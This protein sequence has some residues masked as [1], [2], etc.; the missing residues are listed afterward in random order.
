MTSKP[1]HNQS[2]TPEDLGRRKLFKL[3]AVAAGLAATG[4]AAAWV[5]GRIQGVP[6]DGGFPMPVDE[7][8]LKP[9]SQRNWIFSQ[10]GSEKNWAQFPE[11]D[12]A[13]AELIGEPGWSFR[14]GMFAASDYTR[15]PEQWDDSKPGYQQIDW[16][17]FCAASHPL[18]YL[19]KMAKFGQPDAPGI[20]GWQQKNLAPVQWKFSSRQDAATRIKRAASLFGA[21]RVGITYNDPRWNYEPMYNIMESK[22]VSWE[23]Y[24]FKPKTVIVMLHE[25]DYDGIRTSPAATSVGAVNKAYTDMALVAGSLADFIRRLGYQAVASHNDSINKVAYGIMAGLGEGA[26]NG[27]LVAPGLGPRVRISAV[28]TDLDFVEYDK[29]RNFG[30]ME[31]CRHCKLCADR[32]PSKAITFDDEPS[33]Q[34]TFEG[35]DNPDLAWHGQKGVL[36]YY[37]DA[38]KCYKFWADNNVACTN[39]IKS[40]PWNKPDFWHHRLIDASNT[41]TRGPIHS[42][43]R[44]MDSLFGYGNMDVAK[45]HKLFWHKEV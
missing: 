16:A 3:S 22:E 20:C 18:E 14:D 11:R 45:A 38:K 4:G 12:T 30:I 6:F 8:L 37:N 28:L 41:F 25:M 42:F 43:M 5:G 32:C 2:D 10:G 17:L 36:K 21:T 19:G 34:P 40:C 15:P 35:A 9:F 27:A 13:F 29:P 1:N 31:F 44:E 33:Y 7:A 39:C 24:P 26:R 23:E